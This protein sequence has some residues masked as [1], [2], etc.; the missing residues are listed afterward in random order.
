[1]TQAHEQ[2]FRRFLEGVEWHGRPLAERAIDAR[3]ARAKEVE[4][5]LNVNIETI[6]STDKNMRDALRRTRCS[7]GSDCSACGT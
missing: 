7:R 5:I 6:V 1:M 2:E 3:V 4:E